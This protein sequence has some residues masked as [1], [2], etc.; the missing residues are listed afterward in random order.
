MVLVLELE[1]GESTGSLEFGETWR[2]YLLGL[3]EAEGEGDRLCG[4]LQTPLGEETPAE[5][6]FTTI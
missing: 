2:A 6:A 4:E 5:L 3:P 1:K